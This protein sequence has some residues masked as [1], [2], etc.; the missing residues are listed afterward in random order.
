MPLNP[1]SLT[2]KNILVTGASSGIGREAAKLFSSLGA[3]LALVGRNRERLN[4]TLEALEGEGH[5]AFAFDLEQLDE[6]PKFI[7]EILEETGPFSGLFHAAGQTS[8]ISI[9]AVKFRNIQK[10]FGHAPF[11]GLMLAR[12]F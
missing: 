9:K 10:L 3:T 11:A 7:K 2:K 4:E 6:I 1:M 8:T 12:A 5:R